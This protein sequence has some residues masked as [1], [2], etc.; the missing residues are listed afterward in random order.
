MPQ[1]PILIVGAGPSGL[2][3]ALWLAHSGVGVRIIDRS[4]GPGSTS[5]ALV[6]HARTLEFYRQLG[7]AEDVITAGTRFVAANLWVRGKHAARVELGPMGAGVSPFPFMLIFPQDLHEQLLVER[8]AAH[9]IQVE[10]RTE[11]LDF[12]DLG[13]HTQ[14]RLRRPDGTEEICE[15]AY[16]AGCDGARSRVRECLHAGFPGGT[17]AHMFYV[18]D[19][20]ASGPAINGELHAALDSIEFL[21]VFPMH[22]KGSARLVGLLP[23][24]VTN[25]QSPPVWED[26]SAETLARLSLKVSAVHWFSTYHVHHRVA[27]LFQKNRV[28]LVGD[29]AHVHSPVGGQGMNTGI[30]D[31]VNLAWKL[32]QVLQ[33]RADPR[34]LETYEP[35]RIAFAHRLVATTDRGFSGATSDGPLARLVR[36]RIV[37]RLLPLLVRLT[38]LR[39][40]MFRTL[41]QTAINYR[42][43][44]LSRGNAGEIAGGDRL[45]WISPE[46]LGEAADNFTPLQALDWQVHVYGTASSELTAACARFGLKIYV[47]PW[48]SHLRCAGFCRDSAYLVRPDGHVGLAGATAESLTEYIAE[49]G[50]YG[51]PAAP[52]IPGA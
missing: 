51:P 35:E 43:S 29:A 40:F 10:R 5:R 21:A 42:G 7:L 11:L 33:G 19:V 12:E 34:L 36:L 37:P 6:V 8:L 30:G 2:V 15:T 18:A 3:L 1:D 49:F 39:R 14:A 28:F 22:R 13:S 9:G 38:V 20:E 41:S 46:K 17:Y 31:A 45:P 50:L 23:S 27:G 26:V 24:S 52:P 25:R 48:H 47:F 16:L 44:A 4:D 32:A